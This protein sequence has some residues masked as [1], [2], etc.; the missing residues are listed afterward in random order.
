MKSLVL[1]SA[2]AM[3][4]AGFWAFG[5][6]QGTPKQGEPKLVH[7]QD[8]LFTC[9]FESPEWYREWGL[10]AP[11]KGTETVAS[12]PDLKFEP[13][14]GRALRVRVPEGGNLGSNLHYDFAKRLGY[15]PE[16]IR[17]RYCLRLA[18]D[19]NPVIQGGK[20]PGI[21]GTYGRAG[22]GGRRVNGSDGWS[23][24]GSFGPFVNGR[25]PMGFYVY[26]VDM[27]GRYGST[28]YWDREGK[29]ALENNRWYA[30]E[31]HLKLNTPGKNDGELRA[32]VDGELVFE[33]TDI[34]MRDVAD[35]KIEMVWMNV[36]Q[37]G[38]K[39][40]ENTD[41]LYIDNVVIAKGDYIGMPR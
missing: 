13:F 33:K 2:L 20:M 6:S 35:L 27:R 29:G 37:G 14:Q 25:T 10:E 18:D 11:E 23:A 19:W 34:R 9:D 8:V 41:H 1:I 28:W 7:R 40:A 17:L 15:E 5:A 38:A 36:Y 26:H 16:E 21:S 3:V 22:W 32:W 39:P 31:Q 4:A 30:I 24:R 12:D